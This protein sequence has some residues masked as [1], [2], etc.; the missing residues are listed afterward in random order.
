[1]W[2]SG[3]PDDGLPDELG[4]GGIQTGR[5]FVQDEDLG[6]THEGSC[7]HQTLSLAARE[8][9]ASVANHGLI[10]GGE[11]VDKV[12]DAGGVGCRRDVVHGSQRRGV[13]ESVDDVVQDRAGEDGGLLGD[14]GH[15]GTE[16]WGVQTSN[17]HAGEGDGRTPAMGGRGL[18]QG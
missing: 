8:P 9:D 1:M 13:V 16:G 2:C 3:E 18:V 15:Q 17:V 14:D 12:V 7:N 4:T 11:R 10:A 5:G 6:T